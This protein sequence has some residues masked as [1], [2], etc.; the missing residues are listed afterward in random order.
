MEKIDARK[1]STEAQQQLR[2]QAIRLKKAG[3]TYK[4]IAE[5]TG[6]HDTTVCGNYKE[7]WSSKG[8]LPHFDTRAGK[9][10]AK[11]NTR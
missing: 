8:E 4:E 3:R 1:L 7:T 9:R 6:I 2:N 10:T 11:S 5:I